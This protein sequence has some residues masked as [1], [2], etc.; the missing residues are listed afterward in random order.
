MK[1]FADDTRA[2]KEILFKDDVA[3]LQR[4]LSKIYDW[5]TANNTSL[6][7]KKYFKVCGLDLTNKSSQT[8]ITPHHQAK[9]SK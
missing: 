1:S 4:E 3:I 2:A 7:D 8:P 6:N 9:P 5:S